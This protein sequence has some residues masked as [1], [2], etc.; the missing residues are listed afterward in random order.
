MEEADDGNHKA[1][2]IQNWARRTLG[3]DVDKPRHTLTFHHA[4]THRSITFNVWRADTCRGRL[5]RGAGTWRRISD[6]GDL[7]VSNPQ[8]K[9]IAGLLKR[10]Q[11]CASQ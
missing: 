4:T 7:P 10:V 1:T 3:L 8:K 9:V 2:A 11:A 6:L 5:R